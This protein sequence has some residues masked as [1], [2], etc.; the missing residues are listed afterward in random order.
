[1][2]FNTLPCEILLKIT[3]EL[4]PEDLFSLRIVNQ[5]FKNIDQLDFLW[6]TKLKQNFPHQYSDDLVNTHQSY[7]RAFVF[8]YAHEYQNTPAKT[9]RLFSL[10]NQKDNSLIKQ[11]LKLTQLITRTASKHSVLSCLRRQKD[12]ASLNFFYRAAQS[13]YDK[14]PGNLIQWAIY[15]LQPQDV[16]DSLK[17]KLTSLQNQ[18]LNLL[19]IAV[20]AGHHAFSSSY[21]LE[22]NLAL[23]QKKNHSTSLH[24]AIGLGHTEMAY[25]ILKASPDHASIADGR[26][27]TAL[28]LACKNHDIA[29][30]SALLHCA[31]TQLDA[32]NNLNQ[33]PLQIAALYQNT[34]ALLFLLKQKPS[35]S[36]IKSTWGIL[37]KNKSSKAYYFLMEHINKYNTFYTYLEDII[38][39]NDANLL[40]HALE[41]EGFSP[42]THSPYNENLLHNA[43]KLGRT[44]L[45]KILLDHGASIKTTVVNPVYT[46]AKNGYFEIV[47]LL[48]AKEPSY[49][50]V[51]G[52]YGNTPLIAAI[53]IK[54]RPMIYLLLNK[55]DINVNQKNIF[56]KT[57]LHFATKN[58]LSD[59]VHCLLKKGADVLACCNSGKT[60]FHL[61]LEENNLDIFKILLEKINHIEE[62]TNYETLI[63][64][65]KN[66]QNHQALKML[67]EKFSPV[68]ELHMRSK[69]SYSL[70]TIKEPH[71]TEAEKLLENYLHK[72]YLRKDDHYKKSITLLGHRFNFGYSAKNKKLAATE[73]YSVMFLKSNPN[74]LQ[75][76]QKELNNG[77]L[78]MIRK[79]CNL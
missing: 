34:Q 78:G 74:N 12:M 42:N 40:I 20:E 41:N 16:I 60:A 3:L 11:E 25:A 66:Q 63:Q 50:N 59:V 33:T 15:C 77:E 49:L 1:M 73:L 19:L 70:I 65:A 36:N 37:R 23:D 8:L 38:I 39:K 32:E 72:T 67:K 4:T 45:V 61:A 22:Q 48:L 35:F 2:R 26:G 64:L 71:T 56:K 5:Y 54:N 46:A 27:N 79:K 10:A 55:K 28:H 14:D 7:F 47:K 53:S 21:L 75:K 57:A 18:T 6:K 52:I 9:K 69:R 31:H 17:N 76:Y 58:N 30:I 51:S 13:Q 68:I 62:I 24:I 29:M 43:V 44:Q